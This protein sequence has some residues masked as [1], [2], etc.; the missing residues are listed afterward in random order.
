MSANERA[1]LGPVFPFALPVLGVLAGRGVASSGA[2]RFLPESRR[3][4]SALEW[5]DKEREY[6]PAISTV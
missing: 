5:P 3:P 1:T 6:S 2:A 4:H